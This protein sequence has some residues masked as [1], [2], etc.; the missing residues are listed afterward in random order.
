MYRTV[1][2]SYRLYLLLLIASL[3]QACGAKLPINLQESIQKD[4]IQTAQQIGTA[5]TEVAD[6]EKRL[7]QLIKQ[8]APNQGEI[9]SKKLSNNNC[10]DFNPRCSQFTE[11]DMAVLVNHPRFKFITKISFLEQ[12][13][14]R[15]SL[16]ILA[17]YLKNSNLEELWLYKTNIGNEG[18]VILASS[19]QGLTNLKILDL[20]HNRIGESGIQAL[21]PHLK[22]SKK[23]KKLELSDNPVKDDIASIGPFIEGLTDLQFIFL[24]NNQIS[25]KGI[26][27]LVPYFKKLEKLESI[28]LSNNQISHLELQVPNLR[29]LELSN[30]GIDNKGIKDLA[31]CLQ[32]L[33]KLTVLLVDHNQIGDE[34]IEALVSYFPKSEE[35]VTLNLSNNKPISKTVKKKLEDKV[36]ELRKGDCSLYLD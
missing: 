10:Y 32:D 6:N 5:V 27:G 14:S 9:I 1:Y 4:P 31:V 3:A 29:R 21:G 34:G 15:N 11:V 18:L 30:N 7:T 2:F 20:M 33:K 16:T 36:E 22:N 26:N 24:N 19:F 8:V 35:L 23:L 12:E 28:I 13:L 25:D 17:E